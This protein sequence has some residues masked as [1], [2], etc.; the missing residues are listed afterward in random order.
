MEKQTIGTYTGLLKQEQT[1][2]SHKTQFPSPDGR[3]NPFVPGFGT[4]DW[5]EQRESAPNKKNET[6]SS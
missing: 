5:K 1:K 2:T 6:V 4:K 3:E